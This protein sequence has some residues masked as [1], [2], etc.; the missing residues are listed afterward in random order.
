MGVRSGEYGGK[1]EIIHP[2]SLEIGNS[3]RI[4]GVTYLHCV[5]D[6]REHHYGGSDN[7]QARELNVRL[8]MD[9]SEAAE[10]EY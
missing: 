2:E 9:S 6:Q 7:C 1:Y 5:L 3:H 8:A 10:A 4:Y